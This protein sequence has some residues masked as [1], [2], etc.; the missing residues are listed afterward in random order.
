MY[1]EGS[2]AVTSIIDCVR[3]GADLSQDESLRCSNV[4][5]VV[6]ITTTIVVDVV[7]V[8]FVDDDVVVLF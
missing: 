1:V 2:H 7:V 8:V 3:V 6:T 5:L 4:R